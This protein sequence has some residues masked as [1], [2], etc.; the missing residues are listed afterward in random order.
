[1]T[2]LRRIARILPSRIAFLKN[3]GNEMAKRKGCGRRT[4]P[5][6]RNTHTHTHKQAVENRKN[7]KINIFI[8]FFLLLCHLV[9]YVIYIEVVRKEY[10]YTYVYMLALVEP[11][12]I[13][14]HTYAIVYTG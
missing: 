2:M 4:R 5:Y 13:L 9:W 7:S 10:K 6:T 14:T 11:Q 1:M 8:I 12:P 3:N